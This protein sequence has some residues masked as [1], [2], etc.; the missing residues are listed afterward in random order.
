MVVVR[1]KIALK[2]DLTRPEN[3]NNKEVSHL[4]VVSFA[5]C[6]LWQVLTLLQ[7]IVHCQRW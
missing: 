1:L 2:L 3:S 7:T 6:R 5:A 4:D